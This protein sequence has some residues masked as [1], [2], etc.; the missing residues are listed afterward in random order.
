MYP[1]MVTDVRVSDT[2]V[3]MTTKWGNKML[4]LEATVPGHG[5]VWF[6]PD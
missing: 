2:P 6:D 1:D 3:L 5:Q 4:G